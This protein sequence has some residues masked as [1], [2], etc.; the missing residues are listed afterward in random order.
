[1]N[2]FRACSISF[3]FIFS[4]LHSFSQP[5]EKQLY[6][7]AR[8]GFEKNHI[9]KSVELYKELIKLNPEN[10]EYNYGLGEALYYWDIIKIQSI[11][12]LEKALACVGQGNNDGDIYFFLADCYHLTGNYEKAIEYFQNYLKILDEQGDFL[13]KKETDKLKN[14][15]NLCIAQCKNAIELEKTPVKTIEINSEQ[16]KFSFEMLNE[17]INSSFDDYCSVVPSNDT[18]IYFASRRTGSSGNKTDYW[19]DKIDEDIYY[20]NFSNGK[21]ALAKNIGKPINTKKH[22]APDYIS[23]DG[24]KLYFYRGEKQGTVYVTEKDASGNWI[25]P[26]KL[27][28]SK[29]VNTPSWETSFSFVMNNNTVYF[30]S[31]KKGGQG[32]RDIY[33]STI[34]DDG[35]WSEPTNLGVEIN[36]PY[37]EDAPFLSPD[38]KTLYF[39]STGHNSMGGF[40]IFISHFENGKWTKPVNIGVPINSA[41]DD[42]YFM[43]DSKMKYA[44]YS[45]NRAMNN[46]NDMNIYSI[47]IEQKKDTPLIVLN[48]PKKDSVILVVKKDT[49]I[50]KKDIPEVISF[51]NVLFDFEKSKLKKE[52][53]SDLDKLAEYLKN[54][55]SASVLLEGYTDITGSDAYNL[56]LSK[57]RVQSIKKYLIKKGVDPE[58]INIS[59]KGKEKPTADNNTKEG[60]KLNRRV[61][62]S[63]VK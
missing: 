63:I 21:W 44:Y 45:S 61:E 26:I 43:I 31:N 49:V 32:G 3:L 20:S 50:K 11:P 7:Q 57:K 8:K 4:S 58:K 22:E 40:D 36:T 41:G 1:M 10:C 59:A 46:Q 47:A 62:I 18:V 51:S 55:P 29:N 56:N 39:S 13:P 24:K 23:A 33:Q 48:I 35:T 60:R 54:N 27:K 53:L 28:K 25:K 52:F 42:I 38:G 19:D 15:V 30:A 14:E 9:T 12:Y 16:K 17:E 2:L 37:D 34:K 6:K 5:N